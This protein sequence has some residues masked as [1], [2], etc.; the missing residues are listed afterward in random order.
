MRFATLG[1]QGFWYDEWF[2]I[3][4][5]GQRP[6]ELLKA[7]SITES[8]PPLYYLLAAGWERLFGSGEFGL[9]SL[10]ALLGTAT[11]P[12]VYA[13]A[14]ALSSRRAGLVAAALTAT[15]PML[16]WYSQEARSY[17]LLVFLSALSFF[18]FVR[19]LQGA[20]ARWLWAW[21]V[22]SAFAL[23]AHYFAICLIV[24]EAAWLLFRRRGSRA[25][26]ALAA[27]A[28]L[29]VAI[30]LSPLVASQEGNPDFSLLG[31]NDRVFQ[32]PEHF[33]VGLN[34]P[35]QI[36]PALVGAPLAAALVYVLVRAEQSA[37]RAAA[38]AGG[39]ALAG[40]AIVLVA[41]LGGTDYLLS[42]NLLELW[43]PT[44]VALGAA[45]G[46]RRAGPLGPATAVALCM[47]GLG[48]A[49]WTAA[50]PAAQRPHWGELAARLGDPRQERVVVSQSFAHL[51]YPLLLYLDGA[52]F[53]A[54]GE[55]IYTS[56]LAVIDPRPVSDYGI[57]QC[58]WG[59]ICG[60]DVGDAEPP[61]EVPARF[62]L[63]DEGSTARFDYRLY[64][65]PVRINVS[66][67][68]QAPSTRVFVQAPP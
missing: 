15:N 1:A 68:A 39:V 56:E 42:R 37:Q 65:A 26:V 21:A 14:S 3:N 67:T 40:G 7:V 64:R 44:G 58:W 31:L 41:A 29:V 46:A 30:A 18:L 6:V 63:V 53:P 36:L 55:T 50:T 32:V 54:P 12:V 24:P 38:L 17:S 22:A 35:W 10:S 49:I 48:V 11:I 52:R 27:G 43:V 62:E 59:S 66:L 23:N 19:A 25:D 28:F 9:R 51:S 4:V 33:L 8:T 13:A 57:G 60:G 16:I 2:T 47:V 61:F 5:I 34:A 20:G 45:L